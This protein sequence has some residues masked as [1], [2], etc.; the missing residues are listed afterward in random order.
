MAKRKGIKRDIDA[1]EKKKKF[2][3][4]HDLNNNTADKTVTSTAETPSELESSLS[5]LEDLI[6]KSRKP[7]GHENCGSD[8]QGM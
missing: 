3:E 2:N 5:E 8:V 7:D 6:E 4:S 1:I